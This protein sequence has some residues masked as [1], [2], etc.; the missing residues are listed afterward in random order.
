MIGGSPRWKLGAL[1]AI[2]CTRGAVLAALLCAGAADDRCGDPWFRVGDLLR[3]VVRHTRPD[4]RER[5]LQIDDSRPP[6]AIPADRDAGPPS[7]RES[8]H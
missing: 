7:D 5:A 3:D 8:G 6:V 4:R 2:T 1:V